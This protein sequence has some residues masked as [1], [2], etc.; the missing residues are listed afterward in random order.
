MTYVYLKT[1]QNTGN[2]T[3][4]VIPLKVTSISISTD[5][6]IPSMPIPVVGAIAFGEGG[7][8]ALD[9]GASNKVVTLNGVILEE[10][11]VKSGDGG[12]DSTRVFTAHEIA[13]MI[14]SGVD[15]TGLAQ[16]QAF[17]ELV[18]L[19]PSNVDEEY[20]D[21]D[22]DGTGSRGHLIPFNYT[23]RGA[24]NTLDNFKVQRPKSFP[25]SSTSEGMKGFVRSFSS[26][27]TSESVEIPF[28]MQFE[29]AHIFP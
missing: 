10:T 13:Q 24:K 25:T 3:S 28:N 11:I 16:H 14:H 9:I 15:A 6:S 19:I 22:D 20:R 4:N 23:S 1:K 17:D 26:D 8:A 7:N 29:I 2:L 27:F 18:F 21:R 5:K 12:H